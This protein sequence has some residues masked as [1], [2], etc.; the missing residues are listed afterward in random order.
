MMVRLLLSSVTRARNQ[1]LNLNS[2]K[3]ADTEPQTSFFKKF[4]GHQQPRMEIKIQCGLLAEN[5]IEA[6]SKNVALQNLSN[7][8]EKGK[9]E[10]NLHDRYSSTKR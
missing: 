3:Y 6:P 4:L 10:F 2:D 1:L 9:T 8:K 7:D 5:I